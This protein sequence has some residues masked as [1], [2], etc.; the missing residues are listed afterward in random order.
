LCDRGRG[1]A[2]I[3]IFAGVVDGGKASAVMFRGKRR[4]IDK[5]L[6]IRTE[7][8]PIM[9]KISDA[10]GDLLSV[11]EVVKASADNVNLG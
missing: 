7:T 11:L 10:K 1:Y 8:I 4:M 2:T 6:T 5:Q 9:K 3:R